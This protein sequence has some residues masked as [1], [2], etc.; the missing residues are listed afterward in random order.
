MIRE[1]V[2]IT[3]FYR[4]QKFEKISPIES[5]GSFDAVD[6]KVTGMVALQ[7]VNR[8]VESVSWQYV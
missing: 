3:V 1:Y 4:G 6:R 5:D 8:F 7:W 2:K